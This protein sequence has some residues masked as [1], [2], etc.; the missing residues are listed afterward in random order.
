MFK[1]DRSEPFTIRETE[2]LVDSTFREGE[3]ERER[4][5]DEVSRARYD[6]ALAESQ[7]PSLVGRLLRR[8]GLRH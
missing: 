1:S 4:H 3:S 6:E 7:R 8:V 2:R 5:E